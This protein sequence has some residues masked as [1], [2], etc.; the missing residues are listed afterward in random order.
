MVLPPSIGK[1]S[2]FLL[3]SVGYQFF[4]THKGDIPHYSYILSNWG[5]LRTELNN[6]GCSRLVIMLYLEI[7]KG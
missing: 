6:V 5:M 1:Y 4:T 3:D 2:I 7:Q